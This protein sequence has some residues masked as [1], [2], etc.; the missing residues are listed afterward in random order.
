MPL[1]RIALRKGK[2]PDYQSAVSDAVHRA[3]VDTISIPQQDRFQVITEHEP[4]RL[5]Y[6]AAYLE[7]SKRKDVP[8]ATFDMALLKAAKAS[9]C[10]ITG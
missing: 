1:V 7:L 4:G 2:S 9:G 3:L 10:Q 8:L 6:D 5:I